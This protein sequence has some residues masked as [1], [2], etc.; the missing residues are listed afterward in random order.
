[1]QS[2]TPVDAPAPVG[3]RDPGL[4]YR[5]RSHRRRQLAAALVAAALLAAA[6]LWIADDVADPTHI[7][8]TKLAGPRSPLPVNIVLLL[9]KSGSFAGYES[10]RRQ[11]LDQLLTWSPDN[12]RDD[13][14]IT[15]LSFAA[16]AAVEVDTVSVADLRTGRPTP[17]NE[18]LDGSGTMIAHALDLAAERADPDYLQSLVVVTDTVVT[19]VEPAEMSRAVAAIGADSMTL[20]LP[21]GE[22]IT[23]AW[24]AS[25]PWQFV[26][27]IDSDSADG[28]ALAI[29][30]AI[31]HATRQSLE[32]VG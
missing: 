14:T 22:G 4:R 11:A 18:L 20:I 7:D 8:Q 16:D 13:D 9:D 27:T 3:L 28:T 23:D 24:A 1:M 31:A 30:R 12:L 29:G 32:K 17:A 15:V 10:V 2:P 6:G 26:T 25:F 5:P 21:D 19:D